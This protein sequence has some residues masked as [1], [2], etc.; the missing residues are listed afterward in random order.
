MRTK[1]LCVLIDISIKVRLVPLNMFKPSVIFTD[2]S[3]A[4]LLLWIIFVISVSRLSLLCLAA[5]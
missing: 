4:V 2:R 3:K 1:H 5:L